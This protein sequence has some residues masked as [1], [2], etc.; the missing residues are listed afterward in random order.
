MAD[1]DLGFSIEGWDEF[2]ERFADLV[3]KWGDKKKILLER[4]GNI[5]HAEIIP[6]V[7]VDTSRLVDSLFVFGEGIPQDYVEVGTNVEYALYVNDGHVQHRRFLPADKLTV[8][9]RTKYLKNSNQ[10]GIMLTLTKIAKKYSTT[11]DTLVALNGIKNK[12]LI[13]VGQVIKL[14]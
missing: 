9:G 13:T 8:G 7:P 3:D 5:Y 11:V 12:N 10:K 1:S 14:P 6:N 2:V 4:M